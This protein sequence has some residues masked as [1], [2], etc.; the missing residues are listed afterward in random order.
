[1]NK[2][3]NVFGIKTNEGFYVGMGKWEAFDGA[4][5]SLQRLFNQDAFWPTEEAAQYFIDHNPDRLR[6]ITP[7]V[8]AVTISFC[9][10]T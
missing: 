4:L 9:E 8:V 10:R 1:M 7:V 6:G 2:T 3:I 5:I